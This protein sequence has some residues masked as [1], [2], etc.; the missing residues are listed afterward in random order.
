MESDIFFK[1]QWL[2]FIKC[3]YTKQAM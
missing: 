3:Q 1:V 2:I